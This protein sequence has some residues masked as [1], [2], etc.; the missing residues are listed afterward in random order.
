MLNKK[1]GSSL[2]GVFTNTALGIIGLICYFYSNYKG[3]KATESSTILVMSIV[4][5]G[6]TI[7]VQVFE[8]FF[9]KHP[10]KS[11]GVVNKDD[12]MQIAMRQKACHASFHVTSFIIF[13][14]FIVTA[15]GLVSFSTNISYLF[16]G[17]WVMMG[18]LNIIFIS[19]FSNR[20]YR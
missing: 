11:I 2:I 20:S 4:L 14:L 1:L 17:L 5:I 8:V 9:K 12:E 6:I 3:I 13:V 18:V 19:Y 15:T 7:V 16:L 10:I